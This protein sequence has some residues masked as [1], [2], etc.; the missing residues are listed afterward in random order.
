MGDFA[1]VLTEH[2]VGDGAAIELA[3]G[4]EIETGDEA[5]GPG[6]HD[7][8][9]HF[10]I[11]HPGAEGGFEPGGHE[12]DEEGLSQFETWGESDPFGHGEDESKDE[13]GDHD[14]ETSDGSSD[15]DVEELLAGEVRLVHEDNRAEGS[16]GRKR[17]GNEVGEA[18][19]DAVPAGHEV[20][21]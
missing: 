4:N 11:G 3:D 15:T 19:R 14:H 5:P 6:G 9:V 18:D 21:A 2:A 17:V 1:G 7:E 10:G 8:R 16:H 13:D 12:S 20:V